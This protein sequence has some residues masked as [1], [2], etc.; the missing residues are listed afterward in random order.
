VGSPADAQ[1]SANLSRSCRVLPQSKNSLRLADSP[2]HRL[3][4]RSLGPSFRLAAKGSVGVRD[5]VLLAVALDLRD[6]AIPCRPLRRVAW[7]LPQLGLDVGGRGDPPR[8][9]RQLASLRE[10]LIGNGQL[11]ASGITRPSVARSLGRIAAIN[12]SASAGEAIR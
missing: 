4:A 3:L 10:N 7:P 1:S 11:A 5:A 12:S 2:P 6:A 9:D 8:D